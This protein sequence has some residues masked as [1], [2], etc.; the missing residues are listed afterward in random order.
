M[1]ETFAKE[2]WEKIFDTFNVDEIN[3]QAKEWE[4][5]AKKTLNAGVHATSLEETVKATIDFD[6]II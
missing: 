3:A 5:S 6:N 1:G 2:R 4:D